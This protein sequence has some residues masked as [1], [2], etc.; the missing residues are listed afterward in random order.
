VV[1]VSKQVS[2]ATLIAAMTASS[3]ASVKMVR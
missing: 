1:S 3:S 2:S